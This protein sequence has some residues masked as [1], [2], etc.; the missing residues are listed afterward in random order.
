MGYKLTK[1]QKREYA[2]KIDNLYRFC[3]NNHIDIIHNG[4]TFLFAIDGKK[5]VIS[6]SIGR[7]EKEKGLIYIRASK[8]RVKD[9][10]MALKSGFNLDGYGRIKD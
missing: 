9:I 5:Y 10:Y 4:N 2:K 8:L 7:K 6:N 3:D 1:Q